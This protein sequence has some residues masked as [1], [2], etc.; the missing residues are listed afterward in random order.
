MDLDT[1]PLGTLPTSLS[2]NT[3]LSDIPGQPDI[4][5]PINPDLY[6]KCYASVRQEKVYKMHCPVRAPLVLSAKL[7]QS[8]NTV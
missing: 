3:G 1:F 5:Y 2:K 7:F 4:I 8:D 6:H